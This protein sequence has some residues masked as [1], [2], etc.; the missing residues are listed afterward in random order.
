MVAVLRQSLILVADDEPALLR[1]FKRILEADGHQVE[2]VPSGAAALALMAH[3]EFDLVLSDLQMPEMDG[4][5][6]LRSIR[7]QRPNLPFILLTGNLADHAT[8][9]SIENH[10]TRYLTKPVETRLLCKTVALALKV[11]H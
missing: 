3:T 7:E 4:L 2:T 5:A 9:S 8:T 10:V 1:V 6:L 11:R